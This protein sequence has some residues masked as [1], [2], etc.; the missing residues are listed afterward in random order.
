LWS[1]TTSK[2]AR[3]QAKGGE[4][5]GVFFF[6]NPDHGFALIGRRKH[7]HGSNLRSV[8]RGKPRKFRAECHT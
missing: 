7:Q 2:E 1:Q 3:A 8:Q 5:S 4:C 6:Q